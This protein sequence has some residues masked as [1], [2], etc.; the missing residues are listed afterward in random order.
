MLNCDTKMSVLPTKI[1]P[2]GTHLPT[3]LPALPLR[4]ARIAV[5][6]VESGL[7]K[8]ADKLIE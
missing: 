8:N 7:V 1:S 6:G 3:G 5:G 2:N 4:V